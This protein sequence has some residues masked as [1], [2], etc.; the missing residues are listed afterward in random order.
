MAADQAAIF[1]LAILSL[2]AVYI[3]LDSL[4]YDRFY[5]YILIAVPLGLGLFELAIAVLPPM[6]RANLILF[7][8]IWLITEFAF[9]RLLPDQITGE[10]RPLDQPSYKIKSPVGYALAPNDEAVHVKRLGD[11]PIISAT[12]LIDAFG[13][14]ETRVP[15]AEDRGRFL[16]FFGDSNTF[17]EGVNQT[18]TIPYQVGLMAPDYRPYNYAVSGYGPAQ[19]LDLIRWRDLPVEITEPSG[20]AVFIFLPTLIDRVRG[21]S[22]VSAGWGMHFSCYQLNANGRL[23]RRGDFVHARPFLT[24]FYYLVTQ[25]NVA[26][27]FGLTFP[28]EIRPGDFDLTAAVLAE[29]RR[30]IGIKLKVRRF[31]VVLAPVTGW[32]ARISRQ[33]IPYLQRRNVS[34]LDLTGMFD[35][36]EPGYRLPDYHYSARSDRMIARRLVRD[37]RIDAPKP[38][39]L[40]RIGNDGACCLK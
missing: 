26:Q 36:S 15:N 33:L 8:V 20:I 40:V 27:Y 32:E 25:S 10:P 6:L 16:L 4:L 13:R 29:I 35:A 37:L 11:R 34:Y 23:I 18:E 2:G 39:D 17:G 30:Q 24:L 22:P 19:A 28:R 7:L 5:F 1:F 31:Y 12:Y 9:G 21:A 38:R 14:R 3:N